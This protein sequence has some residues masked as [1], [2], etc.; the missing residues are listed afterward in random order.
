MNKPRCGDC[1]KYDKC[2]SLI[3]GQLSPDETFPDN[4]Y[5]CPAFKMKECN[6]DERTMRPLFG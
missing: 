5:I 6:D 1:V 4:K 3:D 2:N